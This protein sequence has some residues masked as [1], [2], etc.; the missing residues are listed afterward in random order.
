VHR[1]HQEA[2]FLGQFLAHALDAAHELA[3]LIAIDERNQPIADLEAD[4]IDLLDVVPGQFALLRRHLRRGGRR[5]RSGLLRR[6]C[7]LRK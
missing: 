4:Q 5:R 2:E 1:L 7:L 3:A 6:A